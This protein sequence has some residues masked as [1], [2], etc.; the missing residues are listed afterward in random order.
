[1]CTESS[2]YVADLP[3]DVVFVVDSQDVAELAHSLGCEDSNYN[4]FFVRVNNG[5]YE[6][7]WGMYYTVPLLTHPVYSVPIP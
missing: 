4:S 1:M 7:V 6:D 5:D 2:V 3:E